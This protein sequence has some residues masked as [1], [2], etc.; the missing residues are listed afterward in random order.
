MHIYDTSP[1][2]F[3]LTVTLEY[4]NVRVGDNGE[5]TGG[6]FSQTKTENWSRM[7]LVSLSKGNTRARDRVG[8]ITAACVKDFLKLNKQHKNWEIQR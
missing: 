1:L 5:V 2:P 8:L 7:D 4:S 6:T 3:R